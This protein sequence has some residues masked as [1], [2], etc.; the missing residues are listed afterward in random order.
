MARRN[1]NKRNRNTQKHMG[2]RG[3]KLTHLLDDR[4]IGKLANL[5]RLVN[6]HTKK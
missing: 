3:F 6:N 4:T 1:G 5:K 2:R